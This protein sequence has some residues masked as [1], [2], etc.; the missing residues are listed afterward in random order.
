MPGGDGTG[1]SG[2]GPRTGRGMGYCAGFDAP[3]YARGGYGRPF[4]AGRGGMRG[5]GRG[6]CFWSRWPA[7]LGARGPY[8]LGAPSPEVEMADLEM[9]AE[10]L[11]AQLKSITSRIEELKSQK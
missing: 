6:L 8:S 9:M 7:P 5:R 10:S 2:F 4:G 3:G 11:E 1:P